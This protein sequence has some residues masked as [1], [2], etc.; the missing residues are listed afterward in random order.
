LGLSTAVYKATVEDVKEKLKQLK[1]R[2]DAEK[3]EFDYGKRLAVLQEE[4]ER[5]RME[6][7]RKKKE[8][9]NDVPESPRAE[10][11]EDEAAMAAMLG[12]TAFK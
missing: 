5:E 4:E 11:D 7:K 10:M 9:K 3:Q 12:F 8:Q 6:R 1:Q 2:R